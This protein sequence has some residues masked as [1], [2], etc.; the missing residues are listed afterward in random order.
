M[1]L[2]SLP[3]E[4]LI[5]VGKELDPRDLDRLIRTNR[6]LDFLLTPVLH[7]LAVH[8]EIDQVPVFTWAA[9]QGHVRLL[10]SLIDHGSDIHAFSKMGCTALM[11]AAYQGQIDAIRL[12]LARGASTAAQ[13][14]EGRGECA[15]HWAAMLGQTEAA[16]VLLENGAD[17]HA[18]DVR[19]D[20]PL[21]SAVLFSLELSRLLLENGADVDARNELGETPLLHAIRDRDPSRH[22]TDM[23]EQ[24]PQ[25]ETPEEEEEG[26]EEEAPPKVAGASGGAIVRMLLDK[27]ANINLMNDLGVTPLHCAA[28]NAYIEV[29]KI[30]LEHGADITARDS[31]GHTPLFSAAGGSYSYRYKGNDGHIAVMRLLLEKGADIYARGNDE[32]DVRQWGSSGNV[33]FCDLLEE[34]GQDVKELRE[35]DSGP[36]T[37]DEDDE[38]IYESH[39]DEWEIDWS[40]DEDDNNED[41]DDDDDDEANSW[42]GD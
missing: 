23:C 9:G 40:E 2:L 8:N 32:W 18:K 6:H 11:M 34:M 4:I 30:L 15:L 24:D 26:E 14:A 25:A 33:L 10:S 37:C 20:T 28:G 42:D 38:D 7:K 5:Q 35:Y 13:N 17:I 41:D 27:G 16:R 29:V 3:N 22:E 39:R 1:P 21:H 31:R 36:D 12:L 19:G